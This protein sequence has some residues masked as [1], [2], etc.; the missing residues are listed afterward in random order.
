LNI[1]R[2]S[3]NEVETQLLLCA[4][5]GYLNETAVEP[6]LSICTEVGKMLTA[7]LKKLP[8]R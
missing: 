5:L 1:A 3:K 4:K 8:M 2:G 6:A 7:M